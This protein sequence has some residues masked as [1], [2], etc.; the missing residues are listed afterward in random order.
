MRFGGGPIKFQR[1][2]NIPGTAHVTELTL[3]KRPERYISEDRRLNI[4]G[5]CIV[6][7]GRTYEQFNPGCK[8][9]QK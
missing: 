4:L 1:P 9:F 6:Y 2:L 3:Q 8:I 7:V 5:P